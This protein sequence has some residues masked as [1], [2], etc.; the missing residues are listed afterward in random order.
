MAINLGI[1]RLYIETDASLVKEAVEGKEYR[2]AAMGGIVTEIK[3]L[4]SSEF[5]FSSIK[6]CPR[7]CNKAA[8][9]LASIGCKSPSET[10]LTWDEVPPEVGVLV[11]SDLAATHE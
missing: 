1:S 7:I 10:V 5:L 3:H 2:L 6:V 8:H 4:L 9:M 11:S